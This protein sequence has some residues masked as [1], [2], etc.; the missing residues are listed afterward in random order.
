MKNI[1]KEMEVMEMENCVWQYREDLP[2]DAVLSAKLVLAAFDNKWSEVE[3][4]LENGADK[5]M[6]A[7][8]GMS[9]RQLAAIKGVEL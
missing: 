6:S 2:G 4:L 8:S 1:S 9:C 5:E 7:N 3:E